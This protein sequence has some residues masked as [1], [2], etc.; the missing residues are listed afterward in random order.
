MGLYLFG[1]SNKVDITASNYR[2]INSYTGE[3]WD[4]Y[5]PAEPVGYDGIT[6]PN[7]SDSQKHDAKLM[8]E[9]MQSLM[10]WYANQQKNKPQ[11]KAIPPKR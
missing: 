9:R 10:N 6:L 2:L 7:I 1:L 8:A 4:E 5:G 11:H 3:E